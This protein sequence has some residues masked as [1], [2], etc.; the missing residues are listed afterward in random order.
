MIELF[1]VE[2]YAAIALTS[3]F[4]ERNKAP[5]VLTGLQSTPSTLMLCS[6]D[7]LVDR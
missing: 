7:S 3:N 2:E 5:R 1:R 6:S 4:S